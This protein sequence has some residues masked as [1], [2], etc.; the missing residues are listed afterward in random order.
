MAQA[1]VGSSILAI[2]A[3]IRGLKEAGTPVADMTVGDYDAGQFPIPDALR[4]RIH[5]AL[6]RG[7]TNYPPAP[8]MPSLRQAVQALI[9][10][11]QGIQ[12]PL[13]SIA[14]C[15][16]ARPALYACYRLLTNPGDEV[17]YPVPSWNNQNYRDVCRLKATVVPCGMETDFQPT[18]E[19][20]A[21]HI[22]NARMVVLN[23]PQNPSGGV[24]RPEEVKKFGELIVAENQRRQNAGEKPLYCVLDQIYRSL[25]FGDSQHLSPVQMVPE[26]APYVLHVDGI[27]KFCCA[28]GL[29]VGW[30]VGPPTIAKKAM[31]LLTHV[32]AW[33]PRPAQAATAE[34][35]N[36]L[37]TVEAW[38]KDMR[39]RVEDRLHALYE[40]F[41]GLA[42]E[43]F[44]V[45][46]IEPKGSIFTSV[47]LPLQGKRLPN[48]Q[49]L[50]NSEDVRHYLLNQAAFALVP[51]AA[52]GVP[53]ELEDGWFRASVG[54]VS[55]EDIQAAMPRLRL[56]LAALR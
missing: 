48:G 35:L 33:A 10:R 29:R 55:L 39:R 45:R 27:S 25:T 36:D 56:A 46:A 9:E 50:E 32:G 31:A 34:F 12:Y 4:Q 38:E 43:G 52:F 40:G 28:T 2:A 3:E 21:P 47:R 19:L 51:F 20:L 24:M 13:D 15:G 37:P 16:G 41:A 6:D 42:A 14:I 44:D 26:A 5:E 11:T 53:P 7:E 23:T 30:L 22:R 18:A 8:G 17:I 49:V 54:A 1:M